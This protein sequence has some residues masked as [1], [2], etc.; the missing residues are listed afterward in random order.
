MLHPPKR[1]IRFRNSD[2]LKR[3]LCDEVTKTY[4]LVSVLCKILKMSYIFYDCLKVLHYVSFASKNGVSL[5]YLRKTPINFTIE[6]MVSISSSVNPE[7]TLKCSLQKS[8]KKLKR[9]EG[10]LSRCRFYLDLY[11]SNTNTPNLHWSKIGTPCWNHTKP[12][13][14]PT[15]N[16]LK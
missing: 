10:Y 13:G 3:S 8:T 2:L 4:I 14:T 15:L 6:G 1:V 7:D 9:K 12:I 5:H 11:T 16:R